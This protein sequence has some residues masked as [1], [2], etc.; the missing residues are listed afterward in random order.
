MF[1]T[2]YIK[3][4]LLINFLTILPFSFLAND[5]GFWGAGNHTIYYTNSSGAQTSSETAFNGTSLGSTSTLT[6]TGGQGKSYKNGAGNVC[7]ITLNYMVKVSGGSDGSWNSFAL[8]YDSDLGSG[9]QQWTTTG[10]SINILS[11]LSTG[12][13][14]LHVY[15][16]MPGGDFG[17]CSSTEYL[18]NSGNNYVLTFSSD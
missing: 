3:S 14:E 5:F 11:G 15:F 12:N 2:N 8:N 13:Y 9:N 18:S 4:L 7:G 1:R 6:L 16:S 17:G 10:Q